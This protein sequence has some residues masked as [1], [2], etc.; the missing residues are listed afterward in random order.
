VSF[1]NGRSVFAPRFATGR[2]GATLLAAVAWIAGMIGVARGQEAQPTPPPSPAADAAA[3]QSRFAVYGQ[4]TYTEQETD[5]FHAP[6]AGANSLSPDMGRETSDATLILGSRLWSGAE[7]WVNG[8]VDEGAGLDDT[9]GI[10]GFS[11]GEAYKVGHY[12]PYLRLPRA[13]IRQTLNLGGAV[14]NVDAAANQF[15]LPQAADRLV[16]TLGK[17]SVPDIFDTNR[18]AHDPRGDFLNWSVID[19]GTFDYAADSWGY[20]IGSAAEWYVGPWT[21]RAGLFDLSNVPNSETLEQGLDE[22]QIDLEAE[23]RHELFGQ[24]GKID[25]TM[26]ESRGR[27]ALYRDAVAYGEANGLVPDLAPVRRYRKRDGVSLNFEQQLSANVGVFARLGDAG[28]N[29]EAYEF[30]DID[31]SASGGVSVSGGPWRRPGDTLGVAGA[32]NAASR[33]LREYLAAGGLGVLVG[34]GQL[35]HAGR[36]DI[37]ET[38]YQLAVISAVHV[39]L[40]Y[41]WVKN[42]GYNC[43]RGPV[44]IFAVRVHAEL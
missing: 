14:T 29:V 33:S 26:F 23:H 8:E 15:A 5:D 43:D 31:Y 16:L 24:P 39:T 18:Y 25:L 10:A 4:A 36:E 42:P 34:D 28:G 13:F 40:D 21:W 7:F 20:S 30:T 19:A 41:Q 22:Y 6:Y 1:S 38:Y 3:P 11:S 35:P 44:S 2:E 9:L 17:I 12:P 27:M 32:V 37:L